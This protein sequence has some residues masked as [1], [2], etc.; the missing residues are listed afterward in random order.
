[1]AINQQN[2]IIWVPNP[3]GVPGQMVNDVIYGYP[4]PNPWLNQINTSHRHITDSGSYSYFLLHN[5]LAA[6]P[7]L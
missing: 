6:V 5:R 2:D 4:G 3:T 1:M 7:D